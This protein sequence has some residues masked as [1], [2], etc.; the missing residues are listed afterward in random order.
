MVATGHPW[1][2]GFGGQETKVQSFRMVSLRAL[3][4]KARYPSVQVFLCHATVTASRSK[5]YLVV[6]PPLACMASP[7]QQE[8]SSAACPDLVPVRG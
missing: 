6:G 3:T 5:A 7:D 8:T 2:V 1:H 4:L